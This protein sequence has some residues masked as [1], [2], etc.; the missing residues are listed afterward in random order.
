MQQLQQFV[1]GIEQQQTSSCCCRFRWLVD[2]TFGWTCMQ[3]VVTQCCKWIRIRYWFNGLQFCDDESF[4]SSI[5]NRLADGYLLKRSWPTEPFLLG[6]DFRLY[7]GSSLAD[8]LPS[9]ALCLF[10]T[11]GPDRLSAMVWLGPVF[12][13]A[14]GNANWPQS[15][16]QLCSG[17]RRT[18]SIHIVSLL[19]RIATETV[20]SDFGCLAAVFFSFPVLNSRGPLYCLLH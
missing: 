10:A 6:N 11:I 5:L 16:R 3:F 13:P 18:A 2:I 15:A 7:V 19:M 1:T 20:V 4:L 12:E 17:T 14:P 8:M 9:S